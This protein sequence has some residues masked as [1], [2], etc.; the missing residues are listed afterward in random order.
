[1]EEESEER[2]VSIIVDEENPVKAIKT[3]GRHSQEIVS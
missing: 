1:M 2:S 3:E